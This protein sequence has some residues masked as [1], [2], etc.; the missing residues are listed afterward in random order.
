M[1]KCRGIMEE[2]S[3]YVNWMEAGVQRDGGRGEWISE[4]GFRRD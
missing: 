2:R 1:E 3:G 4:L